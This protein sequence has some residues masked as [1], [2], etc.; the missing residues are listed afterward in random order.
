MA[1]NTEPVS[2]PGPLR[3]RSRYSVTKCASEMVKLAMIGM[4]RMRSGTAMSR[5]ATT[6]T[7]MIFNMATTTPRLSAPSQLSQP[8]PNSRFWSPVSRL[9]PGRKRR[10][11]F[12]RIWNP[13]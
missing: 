2:W 10:Q 1:A 6:G 8:S 13:P 7:Q 5:K 4:V 11:C 3:T 12:F 9:A